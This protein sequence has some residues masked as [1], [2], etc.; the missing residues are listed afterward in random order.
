MERKIMKKENAK[1]S[2]TLAAMALLAILA[3]AALMFYTEKGM[4]R[5]FVGSAMALPTF[6]SCNSI[7]SAF[8]ESGNYGYA[9]DMMLGIGAV[10]TM[11]SASKEAGSGAVPAPYSATNVQVQGVDEAD[12]V[13]TDG[14]YMYIISGGRLVIAYAY[15]AEE[16]KIESETKLGK[17]T[18]A[19]MF[20][21][22][23]RLLVFGSTYEQIEPP[24]YRPQAE[25][26]A[27]EGRSIARPDIYPYPYSIS[28]T[29]AQLWDIS[30]RK[31]PKMLRA[32]D[33]EGSYLSSRKIGS[34]AYFV[35]NS[36]PRYYAQ[37]LESNATIMPYYRDSRYSGQKFSNIAGCSDVAY[38]PP[39]QA[40]NF[41]TI[42]SMSM[43]DEK[44][45]VEKHTIAAGGQ[46]IYASS[47]NL[48]VA[49][50]QYP[51]WRPWPVKVAEAV[52]PPV[53][54]EQKTIVHKFAL[55]SGKISYTGQGEAKG[56]ILNQFSMDEHRDYF[57]IAT[58]R[59]HSWESDKPSVSNV[60]ILDKDMKAAGSLE[61]LAP[62]EQIYS[63][64]FMGD[65]AYIVTFK[66]V[67]PLFVLDLSD[68]ND[69]K[70]LGKLK[71]P[72]YSD[73]L[74]PY[75][76]SHIIGVGKEAAEAEEGDFAWYQGMK[77]AIF[78]V[79]DVENPKELHKIGIGDRGTDSEAL[80]NHKAFL[81]D[82]ERQLL[83]I[84]VLLAEIK[85][86]T[87]RPANEYGNFVFQGA[88]V[89]RITLENGFELRGRI[90]HF[91]DDDAFKKSGYWFYGPG[92]SV[93][94]SLYIRDVL[95]TVSQKMIKA[96]SLGDLT[97]IKYLEI[98]SGDDYVE[99]KYAE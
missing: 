35:V 53:Q 67:D 96:S 31:N 38:F 69:P 56:W 11:A 75:D 93:Q 66:K 3:G 39:V 20:I 48:Y 82:K 19:E 89:Y 83:V 28:L 16:A 71:I 52:V 80:H 47:Q 45:E 64:R 72:G 77:I 14:R 63:V 46:N 92:Y 13:K 15:P 50:V 21:D 34:D 6:D 23:D 84:P 2:G 9:G 4:Q 97:E 90:T 61:G 49:E 59:G 5:P 62:G 7:V 79:S 54:E 27:I 94:R 51:R 58:T 18:P 88:Y 99:P 17:L 57:R 78:D 74:H 42:A 24:V 22:G 29:T 86:K 33:F 1:G 85:D 37:P 73:Y 68:P 55:D 40:R 30:D 44:K 65:R 43:A 98:A 12:I 76:E 87:G 91:K 81:F 26:A 10:R 41:I 70:V 25:E 95:Y 32:V 36:Y 8:K 60:Y